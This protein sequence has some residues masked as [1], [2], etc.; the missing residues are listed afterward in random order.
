MPREMLFLAALTPLLIR[1][2]GQSLPRGPFFLAFLFISRPLYATNFRTKVNSRN[3]S[4]TD[5]KNNLGVK[6][7]VPESVAPIGGGILK[8]CCI[9]FFHFFKK[10]TI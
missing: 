5:R 9:G 4:G 6:K 2:P 8:L 1:G 3:R 7:T 10:L